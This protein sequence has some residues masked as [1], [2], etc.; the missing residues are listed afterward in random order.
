MEQLKFQKSALLHFL[1]LLELL[2][3]CMLQLPK[4]IKLSQSIPFLFLI[5]NF[6]V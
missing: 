6:F 5:S 2:D 3:I 4:Y 1:I